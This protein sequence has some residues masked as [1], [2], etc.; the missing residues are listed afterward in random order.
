MKKGNKQLNLKQ[1][2][3]LLTFL[4]QKISLASIAEELGVSRQTVYREIKRNSKMKKNDVKGIKYSCIHFKECSKKYPSYRLECPEN[5]M[6]YDIKRPECLNKYPFV[7]N[8][9]KKNS[10]CKNIQYYYDSECASDE[11]HTRIKNANNSP[12][13]S[14]EEIRK[15][16]KIVSPLINKGQ[17]VEAILMNHPEIDV[18]SLT[19]R[20]WIKKRVLDAKKSELRMFGRR[21][22]SNQYDY[23]KSKDYN[24]LSIKKIGH[25]YPDYLLY[26]QNNPNSLII[27]LDTVIGTKDGEKSVLT[28]HIVQYKFQFGILLE[29]HTKKAVFDKL[30]DLF[31]KMK[32]LED[33]KGLAMY[34]CFVDILLTDNGPEF[35]ALLDFCDI[36]PN[37]HIFYCHP[38]SSFEKG[39]C[40]RNH[41]LVRYIHYK[42]WSFD[43]T[44]Q[45]DL[46]LLFSNINSYPRKSLNQKTPYQCVLDDPRLGK[47]FLDLINIS[48][49]E[50][51]DV[52]LNPS[53]LKK[54][55]K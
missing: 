10:H 31:E 15:I 52:I 2:T 29:E 19:I 16:N 44:T 18:S 28:I 53:L 13:K 25:K 50:S 26:Q 5:C 42:G 9:C 46:N 33:D 36:D 54:I 21:I 7:C 8:F 27:Q 3:Q 23:S 37:I 48:K 11:Y 40:E 32:K 4:K 55:K 1:R 39:S 38:V 47:E 51:D 43:E 20:N 12:R 34:S 49:I 45:D 24:V 14:K 41:E 6:N 35:D 17:S 22:P 30:N